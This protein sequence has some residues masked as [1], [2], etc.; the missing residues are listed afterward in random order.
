[1][2]DELARQ[3]NQM[4]PLQEPAFSRSASMRSRRLL[5]SREGKFM[6]QHKVSSIFGG[7]AGDAAAS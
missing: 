1:M 2:R 3:A 5:H 7:Q 6:H 4:M